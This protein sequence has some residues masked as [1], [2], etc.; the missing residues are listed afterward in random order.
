MLSTHQSI[1]HDDGVIKGASIE[2]FVFIPSLQ[3]N[4]H[5]WWHTQ[6]RCFSISFCS[7]SFLAPTTLSTTLPFFI[8][9]NV[10]IACTWNSSETP[11][12]QIKIYMNVEMIHWTNKII[13]HVQCIRDIYVT[14]S[15]R[16]KNINT[17][18][19][20]TSI[21]MNSTLVYFAAKS[22]ITGSMCLQGPHHLAVKSITIFTKKGKKKWDGE[23][24]S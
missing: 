12:L 11:C 8:S 7:F 6:F 13:M 10:G 19:S 15:E 20:S 17:I 4:S 9:M 5:E 22:W 21:L 23:S 3:V 14:N 16:K 2:E 18:N 24:E 1:L